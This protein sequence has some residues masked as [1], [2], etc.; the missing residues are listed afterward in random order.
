MLTSS[1]LLLSDSFMTATNNSYFEGDDGHGVAARVVDRGGGVK[2]CGAA[3]LNMDDKDAVRLRVPW[4]NDAVSLRVPWGRLL[5]EDQMKERL[6]REYKPPMADTCKVIGDAEEALIKEKLFLSFR[7]SCAAWWRPE[8]AEADPCELMAME[9]DGVDAIST[10]GAGEVTVR[11]TE[12]VVNSEGLNNNDNHNILFSDN[13]FNDANTLEELLRVGAYC[14]KMHMNDESSFMCIFPQSN[15][16]FP[17]SILIQL[18]SSMTIG[19]EGLNSK[20]SG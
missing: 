13:Q 17:Q 19:L 2:A 20:Q 3:S 7:S 11:E 5:T 16:I 14:G 15:P 12:P 6:Y 10:A 9:L 18:S 8:I 1:D 4:G